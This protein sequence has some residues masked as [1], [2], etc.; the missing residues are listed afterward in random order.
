VV[1]AKTANVI[2]HVI[3]QTL[4]IEPGASFEGRCSRSGSSQSGDRVTVV[5]DPPVAGSGAA[6]SAAATP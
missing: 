6:A 3:H 2:G 1:L 4:S 5:R